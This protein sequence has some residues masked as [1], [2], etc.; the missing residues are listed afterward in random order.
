MDS[1]TVKCVFTIVM[2]L[3]MQTG[4]GECR[5]LRRKRFAPIVTFI[6]KFA[7]QELMSFG[8]DALIDH[9]EQASTTEKLETIL[10]ILNSMIET[11]EDFLKKLNELKELSTIQ[12]AEEIERSLL[13]IFEHFDTFIKSSKACLQ[14]NTTNSCTQT[15]EHEKETLK[16]D[17]RRI[18]SLLTELH[19]VIKGFSVVSAGRNSG[20]ACDFVRHVLREIQAATTQNYNLARSLV[21]ISNYKDELMKLQVNSYQLYNLT[22][23]S[24]NPTCSVVRTKLE[25]Q[26]RLQNERFQS[27][28][29]QYFSQ[30]QN[31]NIVHPKTGT[32]LYT[33]QKN[34]IVIDGSFDWDKIARP[35]D[36]GLRCPKGDSSEVFS[37]ED[38]SPDRRSGFYLRQK[39]GCYLSFD[40]PFLNYEKVFPTLWADKDRIDRKEFLICKPS[41]QDAVTFMITAAEADS[42][43]TYSFKEVETGKYLNVHAEQT[44]VN[45][46]IDR[47]LNLVLFLHKDQFYWKQALSGSNNRTCDEASTVAATDTPDGNYLGLII[48]IPVGVVALIIIAVC[49]WCCCRK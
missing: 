15:L 21:D 5:T 46:E 34:S 39:S 8:I 32:V 22:C 30:L 27:C 29:P 41:K 44:S 31:I 19:L 3:A 18:P 49:C 36:A 4:D 10:Q 20:L 6:A 42:D 12:D 14:A 37:W 24:N 26:L 11:H 2:M 17:L 45:N 33:N 48:G 28:T 1:R 40:R 38:A 47:R 13:V 43:T 9:A 35:Q 16:N 25:D 7:V 23:T